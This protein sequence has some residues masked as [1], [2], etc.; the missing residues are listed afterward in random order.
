[1]NT[2]Q[3]QAPKQ[4]QPKVA[5]RGPRDKKLAIGAKF[6]AGQ[7]LADPQNQL[8]PQ[9]A[10]VA[11]TRTNLIALLGQKVVI[12][13]QADQNQVQINVAVQKHDA[14]LTDYARA[15]AA[16]AGSNAALLGQLGVDDVV[17]APAGANDVV[18]A[19]AK[20]TVGA[21]E[22]FGDALLKCRRVAYATAYV[23]QYKLEP[24]KPED[25]WLP[26]EG[27]QTKHAKV[28]IPALPPAQ[29]V[30]GRVRAI[31]GKLGP[32]S[33]EVVGRTK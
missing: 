14:A 22:S 25:P 6:L 26:P 20:L 24:S 8:G 12:K 19:T 3:N 18:G 1:M 13:A 5:A 33:E 21:G 32:W 15:A 29:L 2:K 4:V 17:K 11:S 28:I 16:F 10:A 27:I 31:G 30:R 9:A 23:F 7:G